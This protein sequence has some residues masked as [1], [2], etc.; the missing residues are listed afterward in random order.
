[1]SEIAEFIKNNPIAVI[2]TV[3]V[4]FVAGVATLIMFFRKDKPKPQQ[5]QYMKCARCDG[6]GRYSH[7]PGTSISKYIP[8]ETCEVCGGKGVVEV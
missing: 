7:Y 1:L 6:T 5:P 8:Q 4:G 2:V 3:S